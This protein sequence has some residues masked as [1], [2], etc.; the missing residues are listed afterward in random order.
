[1]A[2]AVAVAK[3]KG[4][5]GDDKAH[6]GSINLGHSSF[7]NNNQAL[8][9]AASAIPKISTGGGL[10]L[11][12]TIGGWRVPLHE[13]GNNL[14][15]NR[16][17]VCRPSHSSYWRFSRTEATLRMARGEGLTGQIRLA[18]YEASARSCLKA[19]IDAPANKSLP[20]AALY[21]YCTCYSNGMADRLSD[22]EVRSL[23]ATGD[24]KRYNEA[25]H[26]RAMIVIKQCQE[27]TRKSLLKSN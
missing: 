2:L 24:E 22:D 15:Q 18:F 26:D 8:A 16:R 1:M 25:L 27:A 5:N 9:C 7:V 17:N 21:G 14:A 13:S 23:E 4:G 19:Q 12:F 11:M 20:V 10:T 6:G 3:Q